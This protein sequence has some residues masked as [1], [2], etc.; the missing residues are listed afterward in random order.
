MH[1]AVFV[2]S[3]Q[4]NERE[5]GSRRSGRLPPKLSDAPVPVRLQR[6]PYSVKVNIARPVPEDACRIRNAATDVE[7]EMF[8]AL[9]GK[10]T[11]RVA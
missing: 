3:S 1:S 4:G 5:Q 2:S 6:L 7:G 10:R 11:N 9:R 8:P